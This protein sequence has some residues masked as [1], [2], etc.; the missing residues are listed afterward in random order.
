MFG[1]K[2]FKLF[3]FHL[4]KTEILLSTQTFALFWN[5]CAQNGLDT[6][7]SVHVVLLFVHNVTLPVFFCLNIWYL[8]Y[9]MSALEEGSHMCCYFWGFPHFCFCCVLKFIFIQIKYWKMYGLHSLPK[10]IIWWLIITRTWQ[11]TVLLE[12]DFSK[13]SCQNIYIVAFRQLASKSNSFPHFRV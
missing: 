1:P 13:R 7:Y 12:Y 3:E 11:S 4:L 5:C 10:S 9:C 8:A 6:F 2:L